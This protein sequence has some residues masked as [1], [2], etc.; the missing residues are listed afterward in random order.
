MLHD[1][2]HTK[3]MNRIIMHFINDEKQRDW[4]HNIN[5]N[6]IYLHIKQHNLKGKKSEINWNTLRTITK[7]KKN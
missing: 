6:K 1:D 7:S 2:T 5:I 3:Q 4:M